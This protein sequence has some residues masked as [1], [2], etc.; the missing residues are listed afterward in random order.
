MFHKRQ[1]VI[2]VNTL[3]VV[4]TLTVSYCT[5]MTFAAIL[6]YL[7]RAIEQLLKSE[8]HRSVSRKKRELSVR[9]HHGLK[10]EI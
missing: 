6:Y 4:N 8:L 7:A 3:M 1:A 5:F 9:N 10:F 2:V